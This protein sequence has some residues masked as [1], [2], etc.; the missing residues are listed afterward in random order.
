MALYAR[1][2]Y[3]REYYEA[4]ITYAKYNT[5]AC[6]EATMYNCSLGGMYFESQ[7]AFRAGT[8]IYIKMI[9]FSPDIYTPGDY[10]TY[11]AKVIWCKKLNSPGTYGTGVM[12]TIRG[13]ILKRKNVRRPDDACELCG[14]N[15]LEEVH[16]T[17]DGLYLCPDCFR[18]LGRLDNG[19]IK[20]SILKF[21]IGNVM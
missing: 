17:E 4:P 10:K 8:F 13:Y 21:L 15:S 18:H 12:H 11:M 5:D 1:R 14:G 2:A 16:R 6:C 9:N 19:K 3:P 7:D 20:K